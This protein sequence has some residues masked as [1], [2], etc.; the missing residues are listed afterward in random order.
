MELNMEGILMGKNHKEIKTIKKT[1][2]AWQDDKEEIWLSEKAAEGW[3]LLRCE[4]DR[5][6]FEKDDPR[7]VKYCLDYM[8]NS[9]DLDNYKKIFED[10]GWE[11]TGH[12]R[13]W[14]Y[15]RKEYKD[16]EILEIFTDK[17]SKKHKYYRVLTASTIKFLLFLPVYYFIVISGFIDLPEILDGFLT[18]IGIAWCLTHMYFIGAI[19]GKIRLFEKA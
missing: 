4:G 1:F 5:Y 13:G 9:Q 8:D 19:F 7:N 10:D 12:F 18:L 2:Y 14:R 6:K 15:F 17:D 11:Y 3:R 16:G